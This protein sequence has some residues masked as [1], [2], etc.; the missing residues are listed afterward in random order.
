M[1]KDTEMRP[2]EVSY[3]VIGSAMNVH[4]ALSAG[5]LESAYEKALGCEF[6]RATLQYRRQVRLSVDYGGV[7]ISPAYTVDFVVESCVVVEI[8]AV[9]T[10]LPV[11]RAQLLSYLKLMNLPIGL[12]INFNVPHLRDGIQRFINAPETDL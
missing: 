7:K 4:S 12:L 11:H 10:V 3:K 1:T 6:T 9:T 8:K 5:L 2:N